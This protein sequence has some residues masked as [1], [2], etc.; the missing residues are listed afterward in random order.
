FLRPP[1]PSLR[2]APASR[3]IHTQRGIFWI[4]TA[5]LATGLYI[6]PLLSGHEPKLQKL[7]VD[8]L[9]YALLAIGV[10]YHGFGWLGTLQ[11]QGFD[12]TFRLGN[13][14]LEFTSMG[15]VWQLL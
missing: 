14:G 4:A 9:F 8:E 3:P 12:F 13:Q 5:W 10:G 15:R 2:P 11:R 6:A 1:P 7:G